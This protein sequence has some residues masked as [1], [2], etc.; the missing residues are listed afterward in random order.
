MSLSL[1]LP[2]IASNS[3]ELHQCIV[4][5]PFLSYVL[6]LLPVL[7]NL[8]SLAFFPPTFSFIPLS[9]SFLLNYS[10]QSYY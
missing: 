10:A 4:E 8:I 7:L 2:L 6:C 3:E 1:T 9:L 5:H